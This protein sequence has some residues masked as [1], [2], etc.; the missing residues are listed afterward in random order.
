MNF[1]QQ[2]NIFLK[3]I[4][5][6]QDLKEFLSYNNCNVDKKMVAL[7]LDNKLFDLNTNDM[8][9]YLSSLLIY[10][11]SGKNEIIQIKKNDINK[12]ITIN[13]VNVILEELNMFQ[14]EFEVL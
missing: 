8:N 14:I 5:H 4:N 6:I 7:N 13:F 10:I 1:E 3:T 9:V 12:M 11:F 2:K